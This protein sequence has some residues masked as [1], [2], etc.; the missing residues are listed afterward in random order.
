M[1]FKT[2]ITFY[3]DGVEVEKSVV[4]EYEFTGCYEPPS[5]DSEGLKPDCDF[6]VYDENGKELPQWITVQLDDLIIEI[7]AHYQK[8]IDGD[9]AEYAASLAEDNAYWG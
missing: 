7:L 9:A 6:L 4:V 2:D 1:E 8:E 5:H 3:N